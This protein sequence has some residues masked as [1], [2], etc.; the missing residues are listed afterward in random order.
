MGIEGESRGGRRGLE[1]LSDF[2]DLGRKVPRQLS[3]GI[4][5]SALHRKMLFDYKSQGILTIFSGR[6]HAGEW[7]LHTPK[8]LNSLIF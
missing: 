3:A 2:Q 7:W 4:L 1:S 6:E 8:L 5:P